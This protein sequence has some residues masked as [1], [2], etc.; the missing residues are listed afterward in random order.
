MV[1]GVKT[2]NDI[3]INLASFKIA[4]VFNKYKR[5]GQKGFKINFKFCKDSNDYDDKGMAR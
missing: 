5:E 4:A 2:S 1:E 3:K